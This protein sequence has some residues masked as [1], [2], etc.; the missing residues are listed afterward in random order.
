MVSY[1]NH[2]PSL[3]FNW[4]EGKAFRRLARIDR[5]DGVQMTELTVLG[6]ILLVILLLDLS[7]GPEG[8]IVVLFLTIVLMSMFVLNWS[9]IGPL[10]V[11]EG[12]S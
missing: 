4:R 10:L 1:F 3:P 9:K 6:V 5:G 7:E 11:K 2:S 8:K 12:Q